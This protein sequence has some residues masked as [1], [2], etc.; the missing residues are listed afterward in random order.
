MF[1]D[2]KN[3]PSFAERREGLLMGPFIADA[4][5]MPVHWYYDREALRRDYGEIRSYLVPHNPHPESI[6]WRSS[7]KPAGPRGDILREQ[8]QYWGRRGIH[9]HQFLHAGENT[10]NFQLGR[11][12]LESLKAKETYDLDDYLQRYIAFFLEPGRHRDT[13][14][15]ESH[16]HFFTL[17]GKRHEPRRCGGED[18]HIG[19]LAHVGVLCAFFAT[20]RQQARNAVREHVGFSHAHPVVKAAAEALVAMV[21]DLLAGKPLEET[22]M[23][24]GRSWINPRKFEQW[25]KEPDDTVIGR[26]LSPACYIQDAFAASLYLSVKYRGDFRAG[27]LANAQV[28]GDNC[29]RGGVIGALLGA[30]VGS[31]GIPERFLAGLIYP[32]EL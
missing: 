14:I 5:A 2:Q 13:Y 29:H 19:G 15:E 21:F 11:V 32:P 10:L 1:A 20:D 4:L 23:E 8:S 18:I 16:R 22:V 9:Y 26:I 12:L 27:V 3:P 31:P 28:G 7:Y 25:S 30:E 24:H 17:Y 6:L